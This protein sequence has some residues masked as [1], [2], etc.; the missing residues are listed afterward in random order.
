MDMMPRGAGSAHLD[1][2]A[3]GDRALALFTERP[4]LTRSRIDKFAGEDVIHYLDRPFFPLGEQVS[5][6]ER[7][8]LVHRADAPLARHEWRNLWL[9]LQAEVRDRILGHYGMR[10]EV[11]EPTFSA[12]LWD[13]ELK[14]RGA[15]WRLPLIE[16]FPEAAR[17]GWR[18]LYTFG[19]WDSATSDPNPA[20]NQNICCPYAFRYA[21]A[22]GGS[23]GMKELI[24]AARA[25]GI[26]VSQWFANHLS[27]YAPSLKQH[28]DWVLKEPDGSPYDASYF[29]LNT[30]R[31]R[32]PYGAELER[33][34]LAVHQETGLDGAFWDSFHNLGVTAVDWGAPDK[35]PQAE[36]IF[37]M[38]GR[39]QQAGYR[40]CRPET[41]T[42]FGCG[43]AGIY[44]FTREQFRRRL[45][46]DT[47]EN[48]DIFALTDTFVGFFSEGDAAGTGQLSAERYFWM[49]AH[50]VLHTPGAN[51]W[52]DRDD[53]SSLRLPGGPYAEAF[54]RVNR[55]YTAALARMRRM[56][57]VEGGGLV[58]WLDD[59]DRPA[60]VW[61]IRD[62]QLPFTGRAVNALGGSAT[63]ARGLLPLTAGEVLLLDPATA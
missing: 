14:R 10:A 21:D 59:A 60:C 6:P 5:A 25:N 28:P 39:L 11:P 22:F 30:G 41:V 13:A 20:P 1:F 49:A 51:V 27:R 4:S 19:V 17:L 44:G 8:L 3:K 26:A 31:M 42:I 52:N 12:H 48:D 18:W 54:A 36:E 33:Q 47:V 53:P 45:W 35:A 16:T 63:I 61:A 57:L 40:A 32:S 23:A 15:D 55:Q 56:R 34:V 58:L 62:G 24:D 46:S 7:T 9:D 43:Q 29:I 38:L 37:R 2:Q 50:R